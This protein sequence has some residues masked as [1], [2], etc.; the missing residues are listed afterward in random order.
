MSLD[1]CVVVFSPRVLMQPLPFSEPNHDHVTT[2]IWID[3]L[4]VKLCMFILELL[5]GGL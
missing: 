3:T 2:K 1:G 4:F 5:N